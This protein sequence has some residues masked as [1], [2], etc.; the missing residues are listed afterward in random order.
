[1]HLL[2]RLSWLPNMAVTYV[3][4]QLIL[5]SSCL[6]YWLVL[7]LP[8][9]PLWLHSSKIWFDTVST[10]T[11]THTHT[12][13]NGSIK[14]M[15]QEYQRKLQSLGTIVHQQSR[16]YSRYPDSLYTD[17]QTQLHTYCIVLMHSHVLVLYTHTLLDW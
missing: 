11:H 17:M 2:V 3:P 4:L 5:S 10:C 1:M 8:I 12:Q 16:N 14:K 9:P 15:L 6:S 13:L 7:R